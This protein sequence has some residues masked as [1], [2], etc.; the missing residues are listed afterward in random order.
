MDYYSTTVCRVATILWVTAG[1]LPQCQHRD[2]KM[3]D[4]MKGGGIEKEVEEAE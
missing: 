2:M 4:E 3:I 1:L